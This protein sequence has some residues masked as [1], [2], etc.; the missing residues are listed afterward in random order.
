VRFHLKEGMDLGGCF[1]ERSFATSSP[2]AQEIY[3]EEVWRV[4]ENGRFVERVEKTDGAM[5]RSENYELIEFLETREATGD[6]EPHKSTAEEPNT[7]E[8]IRGEGYQSGKSAPPNRLPPGVASTPKPV[9]S[10]A[11]GTIQERQAMQ[12]KE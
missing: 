9:S 11:S 10:N 3:V 6:Q 7:A 8:G 1:G 5:V 2:N 12:G 4:D